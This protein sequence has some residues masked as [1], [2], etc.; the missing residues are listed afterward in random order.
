LEIREQG[1]LFA[2]RLLR[3]GNIESYEWTWESLLSAV[4]PG[5][6]VSEGACAAPA[7]SAASVARMLVPPERREAVDAVLSR[8]L[9]DWPMAE[10]QALK[11]L[12]PFRMLVPLERREAV[13]AVL[14]RDLS[15]WPTAEEQALGKPQL[16]V[17]GIFREAP[18]TA[19]FGKWIWLII[20]LILFFIWKAVFQPRRA[21]YT[22]VFSNEAAL[23]DLSKGVSLDQLIAQQRAFIIANQDQ[24]Q[25]ETRVEIQGHNRLRVKITAGPH[26]GNEGLVIP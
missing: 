8:Y 12:P 19:L 9:S 24:V 16:E 6:S 10:E 18:A 4:Q 15:D 21:V 5:L 7:E 23:T 3:W 1:I 11:A 26:Q 2:G 14:S 20:I 17:D 25:I 22:V 13:D